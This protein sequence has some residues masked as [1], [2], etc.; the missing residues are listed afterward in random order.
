MQNLRDFLRL[1]AVTDERFLRGRTLGQ[2]VQSAI[3]GGV[4]CV[5]LRLKDAPREKFLTQAREICAICRARGVKFIINDNV[6]IALECGA[7][8][9]HIGQDDTPL[10]DARALL[11]SE[12]IIGVSVK[13]PQ[14]ARIARDG[15]ADYLGAGAVFATQSKDSSVISRE[16]L[17]EIARAVDIPVVAIG[18]INERNI[19][20]LARTGIAGVA[21]ISA[22]FGADNIAAACRDLRALALE[23]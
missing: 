2:C 17:C 8:G 7:D 10:R 16:R 9:V 12:A 20:E 3:D 18:G 13:T 14:Q 21:I 23:L 6:Q 5:Q 4:S 11:G 15:G 22:I 1:Y 19:A